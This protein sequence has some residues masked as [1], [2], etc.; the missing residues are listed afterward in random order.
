[1]AL[2]IRRSLRDTDFPVRYSRTRVLLLM[3]HTDLAGG[4]VVARRIVERVARATLK[5]GEQELRPTLSAGI[6]A[7]TAGQELGFDE[8]LRR[9]EGALQEAQAGGGNGC[10]FYSPAGGITPAELPAPDV[11]G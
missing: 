11:D 3:P 2:A 8:L 1:M 6:S 5:V 7:T 9:A 10:Q 4:T